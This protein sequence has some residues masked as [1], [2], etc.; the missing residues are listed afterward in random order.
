MHWTLSLLVNII[1]WQITLATFFRTGYRRSLLK[2]LKEFQKNKE[3][4][5]FISS[6]FIHCQA[7]M[8]ETW[9]APTSPRINNKVRSFLSS[10]LN[11]EIR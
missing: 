11:A 2:A 5:M 8:T 1:L 9:H 4:G 10:Y 7:W 6:C 3:G